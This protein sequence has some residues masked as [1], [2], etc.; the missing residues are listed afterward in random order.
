MAWEPRRKSWKPSL[1]EK[2]KNS[3][4]ATIRCSGSRVRGFKK[5]PPLEFLA[6]V[7]RKKEEKSSLLPSSHLSLSAPQPLLEVRERTTSPQL[8]LPSSPPQPELRHFPPSPPPSFEGKG[9]SGGRRLTASGVRADNSQGTPGEGGRKGEEERTQPPY[10]V[11]SFFPT[12]I[13]AQA[14]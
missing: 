4:S 14:P 8:P 3:Y 5:S 12:G 7:T 11:P 1:I 6:G 10:L 13:I 9:R 2:Y